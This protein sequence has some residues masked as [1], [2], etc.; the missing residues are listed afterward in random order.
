MPTSYTILGCCDMKLKTAFP[1]LWN[2]VAAE[3]DES[4][5]PGV[6]WLDA[7]EVPE[8]SL[9]LAQQAEEELRATG[10]TEREIWVH[11][12]EG[13]CAEREISRAAELYFGTFYA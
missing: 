8:G 13:R 1:L 12:Y 4:C 6:E 10:M 9:D 3:V 7:I 2:Y 11:V 5:A